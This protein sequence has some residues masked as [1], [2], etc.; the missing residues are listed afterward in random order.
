MKI[1]QEVDD[2]LTEARIR[3]LLVPREYTRVDEIIELVFSTAE[4]LL[5]EEPPESES[6]AEDDANERIPRGTPVSFNAACAERV[7]KHLGV[8]LAKQ[9]RI[10]FADSDSGTTVTCAV[11]K[12]YEDPHG[13]GYWF[14][15]HPHHLEKLKAAPRGFATIG[16]GSPDQIAVL[17]IDM[18]EALLPGMNQTRLD[19]EKYYWHVQIRRAGRT[20]ILMRRKDEPWPDITQQMLI[21]SRA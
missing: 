18:F 4:D 15:F 12:E 9:S 17:P 8:A 11:S 3:A 5:E 1:R 14:A 10:T 7:G 2:P 20:W 19:G 16:C 21:G 13:A 6:T